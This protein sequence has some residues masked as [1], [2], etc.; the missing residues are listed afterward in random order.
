M[1][2]LRYLAVVVSSAILIAIVTFAWA[3]SLNAQAKQQPGLD[4]KAVG[5]H[6]VKA[7]GSSYLVKSWAVQWERRGGKRPDLIWI[8]YSNSDTSLSGLAK[9][10]Y[11]IAS[12]RAILDLLRDAKL[13]KQEVWLW[14]DENHDVLLVGAGSGPM[15][16]PE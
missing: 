9:G 15:F 2:R 12:V 1:T 13:A 8:V 6:E 5:K 3:G 11:D 16:K 10:Y 4:R 14:S 7:E